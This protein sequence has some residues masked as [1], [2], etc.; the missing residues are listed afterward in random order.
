MHYNTGMLKSEN[1]LVI[2]DEQI[3]LDAVSRIASAEGLNVDADNSAKSA[4]K[5]LSHKEYH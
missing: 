3:I 5:K 1:I 4:L 2:D